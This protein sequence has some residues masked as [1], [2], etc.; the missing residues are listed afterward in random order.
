MIKLFRN[1]R[2]KLLAEN[3]FSKYLAY[4]IGEIFLVVV[5]ILI[6]LWINNANQESINEAIDETLCAFFLGLINCTGL[7][8]LSQNSAMFVLSTFDNAR[9]SNSHN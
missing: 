2:R 5:G 1:T 9:T 8:G 3:K 7:W 4:A 6:A